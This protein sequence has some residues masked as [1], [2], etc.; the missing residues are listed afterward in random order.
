MKTEDWN[1]VKEGEEL[2]TLAKIVVATVGKS[3][4]SAQM[5]GEIEEFINDLLKETISKKEVFEILNDEIAT[6][7]LT[8]SGKTSRLTSA[9]MRISELCKK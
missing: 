5:L 3:T 9:Y 4:L 8:T 6:A 1:K 7:H 2:P